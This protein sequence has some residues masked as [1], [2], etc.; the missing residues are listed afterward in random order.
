MA[1]QAAAALLIAAVASVPATDGARAP[2]YFEQQTET[3][4]DGQPSG[5]TLRSRAW[6]AGRKLRLEREDA[7]A[8]SALIIRLDQGRALRVDAERHVVSQIDLDQEL[9]QSRIEMGVAGDL[10]GG[11]VRV[12]PLKA[13]RRIAGFDCRGHRIETDAGSVD[14]WMTSDLPLDAQ[15]FSEFLQW[16]G[17]DE[18]MGP[19]LD[20]LRRLPGFPLETHS[21]LQISG[22][23]V[24][25]R[26]KVTR[27]RVEA[28]DESL[29]EVP[30]G[31]R[32]ETEPAGRPRR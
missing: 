18:S 3:L 4:V 25:T 30:A 7:P 27:V 6:I 20:A 26:S 10:M 2:V 15:V 16:L 13:P 8:G 31:Y 1:I 22:R 21:R 5:P 9:T 24:E 28:V 17:A 32:Q 29:F 14:V 19:Y 12:A 23:R 11:R